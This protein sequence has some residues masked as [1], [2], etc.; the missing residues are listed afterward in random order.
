MLIR[1][2]INSVEMKI[3][4]MGAFEIE[5]KIR[6]GFS[7]SFNMIEKSCSFENLINNVRMFDGITSKFR[8]R[9]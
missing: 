3:K 9:M 2:N 1:N 4:E 5:I 8:S 6:K 7:R